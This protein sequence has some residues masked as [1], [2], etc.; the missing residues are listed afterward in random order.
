MPGVT[1]TIH[2]EVKT[3]KILF[4]L[5]QGRSAKSHADGEGH[6]RVTQHLH[7]FPMTGGDAVLTVSPEREFA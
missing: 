4:T 2:M 6:L 3:P 7:Y 1:R 5:A